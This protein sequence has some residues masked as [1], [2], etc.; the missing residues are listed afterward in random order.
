MV[1]KQLVQLCVPFCSIMGIF[2][3]EL[4]ERL[5]GSTSAI[6]DIRKTNLL[7]V[8]LRKFS[9]LIVVFSV[10]CFIYRCGSAC[11]KVLFALMRADTL[12]DH[13]QQ[14]AVAAVSMF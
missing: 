9:C 6:S 2:C 7:I 1:N 12:S 5:M 11:L 4:H 14:T 8:P 13:Q 3:L 10:E